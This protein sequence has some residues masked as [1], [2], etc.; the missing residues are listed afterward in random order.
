MYVSMY[1]LC[2]LC[3]NEKL[4]P[5]AR[6]VSMLFSSTLLLSPAGTIPLMRPV[7]RDPAPGTKLL[8]QLQIVT[9]ISGW[10]EQKLK[11]PAREND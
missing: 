2:I 7:Y 4:V 6:S 8:T 10:R 5:E 1:L 11:E 3:R 9:R